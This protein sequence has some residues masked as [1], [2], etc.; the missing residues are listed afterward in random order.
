MPQ[1]DVRARSAPFPPLPA[2]GI[3]IW[4]AI[5]LQNLP[6][7]FYAGLW[8]SLE[9]SSTVRWKEPSAWE[10]ADLGLNPTPVVTLQSREFAC[11]AQL[12]APSP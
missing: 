2:G 4:A 8:L 9:G 10:E 11:F 1:M 6:F 3:L 5:F 7:L 12:R